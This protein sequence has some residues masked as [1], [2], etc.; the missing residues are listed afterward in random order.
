MYFL[1]LRFVCWLQNFLDI[2]A[3]IRFTLPQVLCFVSGSGEWIVMQYMSSIEFSPNGAWL[4]LR[5]RISLWGRL[6]LSAEKLAKPT[7]P[8][9]LGLCPAT[10]SR[11]GY[12]MTGVSIMN[13]RHNNMFAHSRCGCDDGVEQ[14]STRNPETH[15]CMNE[16]VC[17]ESRHALNSSCKLLSKII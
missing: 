16:S 10:N 12:D 8:L 14:T 4:C 2:L 6:W 15:I 11:L 17:C 9:R 5:F 13:F 3:S 7:T 1:G